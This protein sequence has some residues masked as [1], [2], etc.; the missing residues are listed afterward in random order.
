[1]V[2]WDSEDVKNFKTE[3][4]ASQQ[5]YCD[6]LGDREWDVIENCEWTIFRRKVGFGIYGPPSSTPSDGNKNT[7]YTSEQLDVIEKICDQLV[8]NFCFK[9]HNIHFACIFVVVKVFEKR[10]TVPVFKAKQEH[11]SSS[12]CVFVD[13]SARKYSNW[14][15]YLNNNTLE[16]CIYCYPTHGLYETNCDNK[17]RVSFGT[18]PACDFVRRVFSVFDT[19][20]TV[21]AVAATGVGVVA[22]CGI[23]IVGPIM[24]A[25]AIAGLST[26]VY[27]VSRSTNAL[28]DRAVHSQSISLSDA[29]AR[30]YWISIVGS[31]LGFAQGRMI[32][33]MTNAA[34]AGEVMSKAARI[35]FFVVQTGSL[36][37]NGLGIIHGLANLLDKN[38]RNEL[39]PLDVFQFSASVLFFTNAALNFKT[40]STII[41]EVQHDV[42]S[43]HRE[44]LSKDAKKLFNK[45][46]GKLRG[47]D[48][49]HGNAKVV[50][51][52]NRIEN[53]KDL[54]EMMTDKN[55]DNHKVKLTPDGFKGLLNV[56]DNLKIHP[57]KLIEIP[58]ESRKAI[59]ELTKNY[60]KGT[61]TK[62]DFHKEIKTYCKRH[63]IAFESMRAETLKKL[64][65]L[66]G[67]DNVKDIIVG[68][69]KIFANPT[70]HEIDRLRVVLEN[71]MQN[72][73]TI[74]EM[75]TEFAKSRSCATTKDFI[76]YAEYFVADLNETVKSYEESYRKDL[77]AAKKLPGFNQVK[78][79]EARGIERGM[80]RV[81]FHKEKALNQFQ[82][83]NYDKLNERY[84]NFKSKVA[85]LNQKC[86]PGFFSDDAATYHYVKHK[87]FGSSGE[88]TPEQYFQIAEDV[89]G[90][91]TNQSNSV[92]SQDGSCVM[93]TYLEP[94]RG[95]RAIKIDRQEQ[96]G[97]ATV[98][99]DDKVLKR[100]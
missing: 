3:A 66:Y 21:A 22:L 38:E 59:F 32:A 61:V 39:T 10:Y 29:E 92:L 84:E 43:S 79:D 83:K 12:Q 2:N 27:G 19:A 78:F 41:K 82:S 77:V 75:A 94:E 89:V 24:S 48:E 7:G 95:V 11:D 49:M 86:E 34:R 74:L 15:D 57:L 50:K 55:V 51:Q 69:K 25:T 14:D 8:E 42:I 17:V 60:S 9:V 6:L 16:K 67:K 93:I 90:N 98:M 96:S 97:I 20:S 52:L 54:Y 33:S 68:G 72:N 30:G 62:T 35:T 56:N 45:Q 76:I 53:T 13:T 46:T 31:S 80:K 85:P 36:T 91:S 37:V 88:L 26:S 73:E 64:C 65:Q 44:G 63:Q 1:M 18:S 71:T 70:P 87:H 4:R 99:Y 5:E 47:P 81:Q 23:P 28:Y 58:V 100:D 40:A